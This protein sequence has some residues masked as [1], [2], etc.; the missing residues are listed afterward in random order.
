M[1]VAP[2]WMTSV[3]HGSSPPRANN[4]TASI[5]PL[6]SSDG[7][8]AGKRGDCFTAAESSRVTST[9][10]GAAAACLDA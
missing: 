7:L 6:V 2:G 3:I 8:R 10:T 9:G 1:E 5:T 4:F